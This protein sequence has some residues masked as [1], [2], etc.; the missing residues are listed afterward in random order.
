MRNL[1]AFYD[2]HL[3]LEI[4]KSFPL[5]Y[6]PAA[7]DYAGHAPAYPA[8]VSLLHVVSSWAHPHWGWLALLASWGPCPG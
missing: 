2:G 5:P 6:P 7:L 1:A 3:Y 4:A 8:L